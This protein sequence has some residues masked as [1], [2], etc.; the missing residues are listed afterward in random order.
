MQALILSLFSSSKP[1]FIILI[2]HH[3]DFYSFFA[4]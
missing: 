4:T 3:P 1:I 2:K